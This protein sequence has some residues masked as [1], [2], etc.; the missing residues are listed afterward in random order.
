MF[1]SVYLNLLSVTTV[2]STI[3]IFP[4]KYGYKLEKTPPSTPPAS[5]YVHDNFT[6]VVLWSILFCFDTEDA[7]LGTAVPLSL[8]LHSYMYLVSFVF[9]RA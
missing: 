5:I 3:S 2:K 9:L 4:S 6:K 8:F 1:M 7:V